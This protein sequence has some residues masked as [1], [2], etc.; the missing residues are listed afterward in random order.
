MVSEILELVAT[1]NEEN[2]KENNEECTLEIKDNE[3][4]CQFI[5]HNKLLR[6]TRTWGEAKI[7]VIRCKL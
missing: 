3:D 5:L 6:W 1:V 7:S 2:E 4:N